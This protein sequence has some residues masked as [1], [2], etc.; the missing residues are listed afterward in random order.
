[1]TIALLGLHLADA[2]AGAAKL[3]LPPLPLLPPT[4]LTAD[5]GDGRAYLRWNLQLEDERVLGWRVLQLRPAKR[6]LT[7]EPLRDPQFLV[8][9][10]SNGTEYEFAVAGVLA[11]G[12]TT[13]PGN[14]V[15]VTPRATGKATVEAAGSAPLTVGEFK[16]LSLGEKATRVT[17]PDG[18]VLLFDGFRPV[19]WKTRDGQ[20]LLYPKA[21][22]N[23]LDIGKFDKRGLPV[24]IPPEGLKST[25]IT[26]DDGSVWSTVAP[27]SSDF[28]SVRWTGELLADTTGEFV[29]HLF[30]D[31]GARLWLDQ[32]LVIDQWRTQA[33]VEHQAK[34]R[35]EAGKRY[36]LRLEYFEATGGAQVHLS[37][38]PPGKAKQIIPTAALFTPGTAGPAGTGLQGE[39]FASRDLS[40]SRLKRVDPLVDFDWGSGGPLATPGAE[41][42][43]FY[44]DVQFGQA[45]PY[46]TDPLTQSLSL[47]LNNDARPQAFPPTVD[48]DRVTFHY[49]QPLVMD[50]FRSWIFVLVWETW[51]PLER[52]RHGTVY[53]GFA[54]QLDVQMPSAW[55]LGYQVMLNNGFGPGGTRQGV[56]SY[57]SGFREPGFEIVDFSGERNRMVYFQSPRL[58]RAGYGYH[59]NHNCL[60]ASP[61]LFYD[62]GAGSLTIAARSE[63][64]H[65]ANGS[66][67]YVEQGADGVWPNLAWDLGAAGK[68]TYVDT[69]EYLYAGDLGQPLPQRYLNARFEAYSDVSRRMGVQDELAVTVSDGT[70]WE[71]KDKGGIRPYTEFYLKKFKDSGLTG[72]FNYHEFWHAVPMTVDDAY[73]LDATH[74]CN[75]ELKWMCDQFKAAGIRFGFWFRPEFTKTAVPTALSDTIPTAATYYGYANCHYPE[76]AKLL[77]ERGIPLFRENPQWVRKQADGAWPANTPYQWTPMSLAG[78]WWSRIM[79]PT[80]VMS[81]K[82]GFDWVLMDGGFG[83]LQGV[84]YAPMLNGESAAAVPV[85]PY[86]WRMFRS[87]HALDVRCFGECTQGWMGANV[88]LAFRDGDERFL[89][90]YHAGCTYNGGET[91]KPENLHRLYQLYNGLHFVAEAKPVHRF[92]AKFYAQHRVPDWIE[93]RDLRQGDAVHLET[94]PGDSPVA[95]AGG[96][97][98][99]AKDVAAGTIRPWIWGDTVWHYRDGSTVVYPAYGSVDWTK[100]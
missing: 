66:S 64:Y 30:A 62:W 48:G 69:V 85:Q 27:G 65:C 39:Y 36:P 57:S 10:L 18:Q 73:R 51:W 72:F 46:L 90:M 2:G 40:A 6:I 35:L 79:W 97:R 17:F 1:M 25:T 38:T 4:A 22:G 68:R 32:R 59:P 24:I 9:G 60:Q 3:S 84:D 78:G 74:D 71:A 5:A 58:P 96:T 100:E 67:S 33:P 53:H 7:S 70:H 50:G 87:M 43:F 14:A 28:F 94:K 8:A 63:Y 52:D 21:F 82:L 19:D 16:D 31:D 26:R 76:V 23:G 81:K 34:V 12:A 80:L 15:T 42:T 45:H 93:L 44:Q 77:T 55:K 41:T 91:S 89:W 88:T 98:V 61:L 99:D 95:G 20:H 56:V 75:P 47:P 49:W 54:R 83:G 29:L 37:W 92:A 86:W 13:T 11:N